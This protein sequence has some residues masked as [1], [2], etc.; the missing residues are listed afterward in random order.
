MIIHTTWVYWGKQQNILDLPEQQFLNR[1]NKT[2]RRVP[3]I[4]R[5][6]DAPCVFLRDKKQYFH[7]LD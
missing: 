4:I 3:I 5:N 1:D 2:N 6:F 7:I